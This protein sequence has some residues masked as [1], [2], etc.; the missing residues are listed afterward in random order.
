MDE[1]ERADRLTRVVMAPLDEADTRQLVRILARSGTAAAALDDL[2]RRVWTASEGHPFVVIEI[3]RSL[4][5][6][7]A[8]GDGRLALPDRVRRLIAGRLSRLTPEAREL[9]AL[10]AVIGREF[11]FALL[12]GAAGREPAEVARGVEDLVA[13]R[14]FHV[15]DERLD[16]A[17]DRIRDVAYAD[18]LPPTR[19]FHRQVV[20]GAIETLYASDLDRHCLALG[21][22]YRAC[23][24]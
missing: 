4:R 24:D 17:H 18:L 14:I 7:E 1:L 23:E 19:A 21:R 6:G 22:H 5:E 8:G 15:V 10:G 16:F 3:M 2:E 13:R 12:V 9:A 11:E 20:A